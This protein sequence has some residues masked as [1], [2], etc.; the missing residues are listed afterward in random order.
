[1]KLAKVSQVAPE[2][3]HEGD[4]VTATITH[5]IKING[6]DAWVKYEL[7]TTVHEGETLDEVDTRVIEHTSRTVVKLA[8]QAATKVIE[9]S[10]SE[11]V[12]R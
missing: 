5:N 7:S 6:D 11:E 2:V 9:W 8:E 3:S 4:R 12:A 10:P 1:M